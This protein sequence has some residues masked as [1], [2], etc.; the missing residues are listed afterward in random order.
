MKRYILYLLVGHVVSS[1][2]HIVDL[3]LHGRT[4]LLSPFQLIFFLF[5]FLVFK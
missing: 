5:F 4:I 2:L 1:G 3:I